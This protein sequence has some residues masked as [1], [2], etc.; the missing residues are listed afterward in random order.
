MVSKG[1]IDAESAARIAGML[2]GG[3]MQAAD[4]KVVFEKSLGFHKK[5]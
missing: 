4:W 1:L 5:P 2:A 3:K